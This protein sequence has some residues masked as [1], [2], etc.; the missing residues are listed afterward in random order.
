LIVFA[1]AI[2]LIEQ[3][4]ADIPPPPDLV[5][6][7]IVSIP[8]ALWWAIITVTTV[9]YGDVLPESYVG[10]LAGSILLVCGILLISIP[11]AVIGN[12]F[13]DVYIKETRENKELQRRK[14]RE[15]LNED[16]PHDEKNIIQMLVE[17]N[18]LEEVNERIEDQLKSNQFLYRSLTRDALKLIDQIE[19]AEKQNNQSENKVKFQSSLVKSIRK[20]VSLRRKTQ[21]PLKR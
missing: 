12:Q 11:V 13:Q 5:G 6:H 9:G 7:T 4:F 18:E 8:D 19:L 20:R 16:L 1:C 3:I 21:L 15:R 2:Y 14:T 17:L 10:K